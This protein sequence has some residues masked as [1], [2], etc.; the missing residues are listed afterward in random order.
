MQEGSRARPKW[1]AYITYAMPVSAVNL[2]ATD[3]VLW[4]DRIVGHATDSQN[5]VYFMTDMALL[6]IK[7]RRTKRL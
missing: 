4:L 3:G 6:D 5:R 7:I 2:G 1:H